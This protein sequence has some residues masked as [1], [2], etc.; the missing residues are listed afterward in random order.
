MDKNSVITVKIYFVDPANFISIIF[1]SLIELEFETYSIPY[2][3]K[4]KLIGLIPENNR[5]IV[6]L[7]I[8]NKKEVD[9]YIKY[10]EDLL[11]LS[12]EMVQL[13][14]FVY[15]NMDEETKN[16]FLANNISTI[17]FSSVQKDSISIMKNILTMFEARGKRAFIRT[18]V[19]GDCK[20]YF[21]L[22]NKNEPLVA[23]IS[24]ISA[25][26]FSCNLSEEIKFYFTK[27][28]F[29]DDVTLVL[30]GLRI[31][32]T[33]KVIGFS[34]ENPNFF[35]FK[36]CN[37]RIQD[38]KIIYEEK[39]TSENVRKIHEYIR[40]CLQEIVITKLEEMSKK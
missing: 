30:R 34:S 21:Y 39:A 38:N 6:F 32:V 12:G 1:N 31:K 40:K 8:K 37:Y 16:K 9:E 4:D 17:E 5:N 23:Q 11:K 25:T 33:A 7:T 15:D 29:I 3:Y 14:A 19:V 20:A 10:A 26:A 24:D 35:I 13:G 22:K 2:E 36:I 27:G 28:D 18:K